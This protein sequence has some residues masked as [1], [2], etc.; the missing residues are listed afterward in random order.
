MLPFLYEGFRSLAL[1]LIIIL[2]SAG[3]FQDAFDFQTEFFRRI[4]RNGGSQMSLSHVLKYR[5]ILIILNTFGTLAN[6]GLLEALVGIMLSTIWLNYYLVKMVDLLPPAVYGMLLC[7]VMLEMS[8]LSI[9][10]EE[11]AG[12][13][14][15]SIRL[16]DSFRRETIR[17]QSSG[18]RKYLLKVVRSLREL[19]ISVGIPGFTFFS[20]TRSTKKHIVSFIVDN[21]INAL[22]TF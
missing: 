16:L 15:A 8:A 13:N 4:K 12:I 3:Q 20:F 11:S 21:T 10:I 17:L 6:L 14:E 7:F 22:L 2:L 18:N 19:N 1:V 5:E 9:G